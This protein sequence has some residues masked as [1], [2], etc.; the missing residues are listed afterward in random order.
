MAS[1]SSITG[2]CLRDLE[3]AELSMLSLAP[4]LTEC[5]IFELLHNLQALSH[6]QPQTL[7]M[8]LDACAEELRPEGGSLT[9]SLG[10]RMVVEQRDFGA[11]WEGRGPMVQLLQ[12]RHAVCHAAPAADEH[13]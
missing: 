13:I 6:D 2:A 4:H 9:K 8:H 3:V 7:H 10:P 5:S 11:P 1:A 12:Q